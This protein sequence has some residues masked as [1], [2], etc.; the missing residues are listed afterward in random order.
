[1]S[2]MVDSAAIQRAMHMK[3]NCRSYTFALRYTE[4][5]SLPFI[6]LS[7]EWHFGLAMT[8]KKFN[9]LK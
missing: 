5:T 3:V 4:I 8:A 9:R 1:M 6:D 2:K 7:K